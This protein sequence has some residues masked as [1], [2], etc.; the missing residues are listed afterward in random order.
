MKKPD[1][2]ENKC[3]ASVIMASEEAKYP[4]TTSAHISIKHT[5]DTVNNLR[6]TAFVWSTFGKS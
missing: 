4:P 5:T 2:S 1:K 3:A 6:I